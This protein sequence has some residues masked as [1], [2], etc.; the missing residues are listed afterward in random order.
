MNDDIDPKPIARPAPVA[1][2]SR[3]GRSGNEELEATKT[4][5]T[6]EKQAEENR[7]DENPA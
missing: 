2:P 7:Q 6:G 1:P 4:H 5:R 3:E